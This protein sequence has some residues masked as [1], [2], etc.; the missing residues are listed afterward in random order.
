MAPGDGHALLAGLVAALVGF[1]SSFAVVLA[2]L[3]AVGAT[4]AQAASGLLALC[5]TMGALGIAIPARTK[6]PISIAWSTPGAALLVAAGRAHYGFREAVG[7]FL[8]SGALVVASAAVGPLGRLVRAIPPAVGSAMLAG[9]LLQ[10]CLAP[11]DAV[12]RLPRLAI[13][14]VATW[15]VLDRLVPRLAVPGAVIATVVAVGLT[16]P[17]GAVLGHDGLPVLHLTTPSFAVASFVGIAVPLFVVTMAAQN[18]PGMAVLSTFGYQPELRPL[19]VTTGGA[20]ALAAPFGAHSIN[21]AAITAALCAGPEV[22]RDP[23]RRWLAA[24]GA[25]TTY[26]VL[27]LAAGAL[28]TVASVAPPLLLETVAGVAL[29]RPLF[30]SL[31][32][33]AAAGEPMRDAAVV[34]FVVT[35]SGISAAGIGSPFWGLVAG[36]VLALLGPRRLRRAR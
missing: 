29:L 4:E 12:V 33:L 18:V 24:A 6:M 17:L 14:V 25:G 16:E 13:P 28:A 7:A 11:V 3:R 22:H 8:L 34:T 9:I 26:L 10:L 1:T 15:L 5:V 20:T 36:G 21:L 27:G 19:L 2:G 35:A 31:G 30:A 23:A 32:S